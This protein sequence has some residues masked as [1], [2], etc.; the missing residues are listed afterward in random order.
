MNDTR[1]NEICDQALNEVESG[2]L[3]YLCDKLKLE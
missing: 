2:I 1:E 3:K